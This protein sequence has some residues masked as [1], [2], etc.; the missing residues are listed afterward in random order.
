MS[1]RFPALVAAGAA[2]VSAALVVGGTPT[3]TDAYPFVVQLESGRGPYCG[4]ALVAPT[5]V[6]TAA[7]C[8][9]YEEIS[10]VGGRTERDGTDGRAAD[11]VDRWVHPDHDGDTNVNDIAVLTL[12]EALPYE[13]LPVAEPGDTGLYAPGTTARVLGWGQTSEVGPAAERLMTAEVP[14]LSDADCAAAYAAFPVRFHAAS[15]VCAGLPEG[16]VDA[17]AQDSGGPLVIDGVLA[18]VVSWGNGC[19]R[20][21]YPGVYARVTA[22]AED[23]REQLGR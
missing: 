11:V 22:F 13:T 12:G 15:M 2:L 17:C 14:V 6:V 19:A 4:G 8:V 21:G 10:A 18:G 23:V 7:H 20:A 5:K 1:V 16:G 9:V 3:A